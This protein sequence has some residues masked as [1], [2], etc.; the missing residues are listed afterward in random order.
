MSIEK[1]TF[2]N[3]R[4][5][6]NLHKSQK[7]SLFSLRQETQSKTNAMSKENNSLRFRD[8]THQRNE[9][10]RNWCFKS[11]SELWSNEKNL[12]IVVKKKWN[13]VE[14]SK[15][16]RRNMRRHSTSSRL[17][18]IETSKRHQNSQKSAKSNEHAYIKETCWEVH[19]E[20]F[21]MRND[22]IWSSRTSK[23]ISIVEVIKTIVS[24][25]CIKLHHKT[26]KVKKFYNRSYVR[27]DNDRCEWIY[28]K[29]EIYI[30]QDH[31]DDKTID[32]FIIKNN[33]LRRRN[34]KK[35]NF[36]QKQIVHFQV[37]EKVNSS[38]WHE[39]NNVDILSFT[40]EWS[41]RKN[42]SNV[43]NIFKNLL[44][45]WKKELNQTFAHDSN[46]HQ[47]FIQRKHENDVKRTFARTNDQTKHHRNNV[48]SRD[49]IVRKQD[50]KQLRQ[51]Q[52]KI[53][54]SQEENE[55]KSEH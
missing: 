26:I 42:E 47:F 20:L 16:I 45:K 39:T 10:H 21:K 53:K 54:E 24:K 9:Q 49:A 36:E 33:I 40:N 6:H 7:S 4:K 43:K 23:Q 55:T 38:S 12:E 28:Q 13:D 17:K 22:E 27:H 18:N 15:N 50:E 41:N 37:H 2:K 8:Q 34:L 3:S 19:K 48:Q 30:M 44:L 51:N 1:Y 25:H 5:N 29:R 46:D 32:V 35:N 31:N 52:I 11:K 14:K